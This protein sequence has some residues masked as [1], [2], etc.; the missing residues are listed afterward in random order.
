[1]GIPYNLQDQ[2]IIKKKKIKLKTQLKKKK[3]T[4][5][6]TSKIQLA[7]ALAILNIFNICKSCKDLPSWYDG[8]THITLLT[9]GRDFVLLLLGCLAFCY[10]FFVF[11]F[12]SIG[13]TEAY[14]GPS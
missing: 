1:M 13:P 8:I 4:N 9:M 3:Q 12:F 6:Y 5:I 2:G 14:L 11:F 7:M 10:F